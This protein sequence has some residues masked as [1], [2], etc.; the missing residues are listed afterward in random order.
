MIMAFVYNYFWKIRP[1]DP[2]YLWYLQELTCS[3]T[4]GIHDAAIFS[5][6]S[7]LEEDVFVDCD[8][9]HVMPEDVLII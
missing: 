5:Q 1:L 8:A 7:V 9:G 4:N 6:I 3:S 2:L